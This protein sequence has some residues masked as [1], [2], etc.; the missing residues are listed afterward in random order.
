M[1]GGKVHR[2]GWHRKEVVSK[3]PIEQ[4]IFANRVLNPPGQAHLIPR[5]G[6]RV[7]ALMDGLETWFVFQSRNWARTFE[8]RGNW[9][10]T[11]EPP[12]PNSLDSY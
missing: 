11:F 10:S 5:G 3:P 8:R 12:K 2:R 6:A 7:F 9:T 1:T 4:P